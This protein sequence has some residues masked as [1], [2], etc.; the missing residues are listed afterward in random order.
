MTTAGMTK[1]ELSARDA[2]NVACEE[3]T[4]SL[5]RD[6][7]DGAPSTEQSA[8]DDD[9]ALA[10]RERTLSTLITVCACLL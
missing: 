3:V 1:Q 2:P 7:G 9:K 5:I 6:H 8:S 4:V 10:A